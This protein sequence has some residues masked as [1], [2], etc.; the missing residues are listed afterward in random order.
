VQTR[1]EKRNKNKKNFWILCG[2]FE[3][4]GLLSCVVWLICEKACPWWSKMW[5]FMFYLQK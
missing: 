1:K 2:L 3:E 4:G 5:W